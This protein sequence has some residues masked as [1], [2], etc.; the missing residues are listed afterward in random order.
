MNG[1]IDDEAIRRT[2]GAVQKSA[3][4][5]VLQRLDNG[6]DLEKLDD[7]SAYDVL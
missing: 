7:V 1:L 6:A 5:A 3:M 4:L 2:D